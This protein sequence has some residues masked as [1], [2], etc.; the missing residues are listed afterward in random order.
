MI[1]KT[2]KPQTNKIP[3]QKTKPINK[4]NLNTK[5]FFEHGGGQTASIAFSERL[6]PL[7][8]KIHRI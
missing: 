3:T 2:Q 4:R 7:I 1:K 8:L 6:I 5:T